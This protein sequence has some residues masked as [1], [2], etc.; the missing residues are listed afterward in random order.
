MGF[1]VACSELKAIPGPQIAEQ[2]QCSPAFFVSCCETLTQNRYAKMF[3]N[4]GYTLEEAAKEL[5]VQE[6]ELFDE[7]N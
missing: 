1:G 6:A 2:Q 7:K 3:I 5:D 4:A